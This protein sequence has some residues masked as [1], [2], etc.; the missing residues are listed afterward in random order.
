MEA[1]DVAHIESELNVPVL[2]LEVS[3]TVVAPITGEVLSN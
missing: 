3:V 1:T 2:E